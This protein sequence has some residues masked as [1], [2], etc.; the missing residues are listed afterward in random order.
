MAKKAAKKTA[1]KSAAKSAKRSAR[2]RSSAPKKISYKPTHSQ[3]VI[4]NLVFK[5][6]GAAI[7]FY[8]RAFG[9]QELMRM[10]APDGRG[11]W[12]AELRI[13]DAIVYLND[14]SP[15]GGAV[16]VSL[17]GKPT[18][19]LQL[20]V[21][22]VDS[23]FNKAVQAGAKPTMPVSDMFWGDRMGGVTDP[24]G[25]MWMISTHVKDMT[26]DEMRKA[27]QDFAAKMAQQMG[28]GGG[29]TGA[30]SMT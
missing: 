12:H 14:E 26:E 15:M 2:A 11:V 17:G 30:A 10:M 5:D 3:D 21:R 22:D 19:S 8:K 7:D 18:A 6:S 9:A 23:T 25:Q 28:E 4:A 20:Y 29:P 24:F 16:A 13:G 27:G 1:K